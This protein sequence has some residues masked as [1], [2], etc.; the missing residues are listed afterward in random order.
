MG[1]KEKLIQRLKS[2][3]KDM[4]FQEIETLLRYLSYDC[5]LSTSLIALF[6]DVTPEY[7]S[8]SGVSSVI[9]PAMPLKSAMLIPTMSV[10]VPEP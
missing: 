1:Q 9:L 3:P 6:M 5:L 10:M 2:K 4:T 8:M 7:A